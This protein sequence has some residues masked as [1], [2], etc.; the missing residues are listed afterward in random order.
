[1]FGWDWTLRFRWLWLPLLYRLKY[2]QY[3]TSTT[4]VNTYRFAWLSSARW[5]RIIWTSRYKKIFNDVT[6]CKKDN[7]GG[8][9]LLL[10]LRGLVHLGVV[11]LPHTAG[12]HLLW[13]RHPKYRLCYRSRCWETTFFLKLHEIRLYCMLPLS[14]LH[15]LIDIFYDP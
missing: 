6:A 5:L 11:H 8:R 15:W 12:R 2:L 3:V 7:L 14:Y 9:L 10:G 4:D 1:M 13:L